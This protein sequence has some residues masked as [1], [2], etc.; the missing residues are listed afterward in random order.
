VADAKV[1]AICNTARL[2]LQYLERGPGERIRFP[3]GGNP[4]L[5]ESCSEALDQ[6][7]SLKLAQV[8][9]VLTDLESGTVAYVTLFNRK[10]EM[11]H[12]C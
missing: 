5:P 2:H 8:Q 7:D 12:P 10:N 3:F 6:V 4:A 11:V 9:S 1:D